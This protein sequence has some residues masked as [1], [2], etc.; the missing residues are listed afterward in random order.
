MAHPEAVRNA[1]KPEALG[2]LPDSSGS[3]N[4]LIPAFLL[5][6][7]AGGMLLIIAAAAAIIWANSPAAA[8]YFELRDTRVG[9]EPWLL[10]LS[11]NGWAAD[12]LLAVFF[13]IVGLEL[14]REIVLGE[15]RNFRTAI[16]P[17][18][19]AVGG[20][21]APIII[22]FVIVGGQRDLQTGW[23][24]PTATD[25]AFAVSVLA[26]VGSHLPRALRLFLLT[27]AVVDDLFAIG[28]IAIF[29]TDQIA[30]VPLAVA[31]AIIAFYGLIAQLFREQFLR[32]RILAWVVLLPLGVVAWAFMHAS[33]IHAT[34]AGVLLGF[35]IPVLHRKGSAFAASTPGLAEDLEHRLMPLSSL[36]A[37]PI[38]AFFSAGVAIGGVTGFGDALAAPLSL[39]IILALLF[40]KPIGV[41]TATLII[42]KVARVR[43]DP[44]LRWLDLTGVS[45]LAA[46]GFTVSLLIAELSFE[47]GDTNSD[48]AKI[49]I[50]TA[51]M[52]A[53]LCAG[54]LL[55]LRN[56]RY[57]S[58]KVGEVQEIAAT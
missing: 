10:N 21:I 54:L 51:S 27:L 18:T 42:N 19:A 7:S 37:V 28:I 31:I 35:V 2:A 26:L 43:L 20:V 12:G 1:V 56:R 34:I 32:H 45:L 50:L 39:A 23:A 15:L 38:F 5:K 29:Y 55:S 49:A 11:L 30:F 57:K 14:K 46:I 53:A 9:Y 58:G 16:V 17:I 33:G 3:K 13:F 25:I 4:S 6:D 40:G 24:I 41:L 52:I 47:P 22:Y 8:Q 48:Y 44:T 36:I